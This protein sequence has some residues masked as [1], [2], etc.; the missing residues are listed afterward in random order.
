MNHS[1]KTHGTQKWFNSIPALLLLLLS[2]LPAHA[3]NASLKQAEAMLK[4]GNAKAA[5]ALL[6]PLESENA[7]DVEFDYL[8][9]VSA[10]DSGNSSRAMFALERVLAVNPNHQQARA[11]IARAH[12]M[13]GEHDSARQE[14][15]HVLNQQPPEEAI[16]TINRYLSA[17]DRATGETTR[18]AAY[19]EAT[20]GHDT[21]INSAPSPGQVLANVSGIPLSVNIS[22]ANAEMSS[23]FMS[24]GGG[25]SFQHPLNKEFTLLGGVSGSNRVNL[26]GNDNA[27]LFDTSG[28]DFNLGLRYSK[29]KNTVTANW[30]DS[31]FNL[32]GERF[33]HSYGLTGQWQHNLDDHNQVSVFGQATRIEYAA[34]IRDADRYVLGGGYGHAFKGD[35]SPVLFV[36]AYAGEEKERESNVAFLG[37]DLW[38]MRAG[39]QVTLNPKTVLFASAGY[40]D[41]N[42]GG[43]RPFFT[44]SQ[45][46]QQTD[47]TLGARFLPMA[48]WQIKPQLTYINNHSNI[49]ITDYDRYMLSVSFRHEFEW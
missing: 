34:D 1:F 33:R 44:K 41:R 11:E 42:W 9:A 15:K 36:S 47:V 23:N 43:T 19:L 27:Q 39:G 38:G 12:F 24:F 40:E 7:G 10:L 22:G 17:I 46:D 21:N 18:F 26:S 4:A 2:A 6:E 3:E 48:R 45:D 29:G 14:F 37:H 8:L 13:L 5:Y 20:W 28:L 16:R 25:A 49:P 30:Q 35:L 32:N 31:N